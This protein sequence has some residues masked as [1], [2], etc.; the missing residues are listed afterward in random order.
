M[1]R[2]ALGMVLLVMLW[3]PPASAD[4]IGVDGSFHEFSFGAATSAVVTC[5]GVS[6][7]PTVNP[8]AEQ[9]SSPP[10][11][12]SGPA[13]V[14]ITDLFQAGDRFE[15]FDNL[16]SLGVTSVVANTGVS[17]CNGDIGCALASLAYSHA[18]FSLG[19]GAHSITIDIIQNATRTS[20]G[21]AVFSAVAAVPEPG[22]W[23]LLGSGLASLG[24]AALHRRRAVSSAL[25]G[26]S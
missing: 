16:S 1:I 17:T 3:I 24:L 9:T 23:L 8:L 12:F 22:T 26:G 2:L 6:C 20:G 21:A 15:V 11:T 18:S 7:T 10:W 5:G 25:P 13:E 19:A 4:P 14:L